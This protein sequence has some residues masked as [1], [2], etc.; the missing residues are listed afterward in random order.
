[1]SL[2]ERVRNAE[3]SARCPRKLSEAVA[4][5][6]RPDLNSVLWLLLVGRSWASGW[7]AESPGSSSSSALLM[8]RLSQSAITSL[9][10]LVPLAEHFQFGTLF[11]KF[12][13]ISLS[14]SL[15]LYVHIYI[16]IYIH[17]YKL[18]AGHLKQHVSP[19]CC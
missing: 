15:S 6:G 5:W 17:I 9:N 8:S 16:Y 14:L 3:R 10:F 2:R 11:S 18:I 4:G 1:M 13:Y 7:L 12:R 19:R